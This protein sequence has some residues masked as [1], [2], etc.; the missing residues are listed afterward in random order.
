MHDV[1]G[2]HNLNMWG[3]SKLGAHAHSSTSVF[4]TMS[5]VFLPFS[6]SGAVSETENLLHRSTLQFMAAVGSGLCAILAMRVFTLIM[7][8]K[9]GGR[10]PC[11]STCN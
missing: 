1:K 8:L 5:T 3:W 2:R 6:P 10:I 7:S 11:M 9:N 4:K